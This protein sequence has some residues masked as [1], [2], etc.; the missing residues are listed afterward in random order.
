MENNTSLLLDV[1]NLSVDFVTEN[2]PPAHA[3][4]GVSFTL[5]Q[6]GVLGIVGESGCGKTTLMLALLRLLAA[7]GRI[8]SGE[9]LFK[10]QDLLDLTE[11]EMAGVRWKDI[12]MIFQ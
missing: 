3:I 12:S 2:E 7:T 4:E 1:R 9:I 5:R 6:G 10:G 8:V 11:K